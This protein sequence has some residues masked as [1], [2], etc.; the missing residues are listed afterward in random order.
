MP[1]AMPP[2]MPPPDT[3]IP[4][5]SFNKLSFSHDTVTK[6]SLSSAI[7]GELFFYR[8]VPPPLIH[9]FPP[10]LSFN[11]SHSPT[12][13]TIQ[14][15]H[16]VTLST[17]LTAGQL[18]PLH[19]AHVLKSL[20]TLH[21]FDSH[22]QTTHVYANHGR[23][24]EARF[25]AYEQSVY[26][27]LGLNKLNHFDSLLRHL[28]R[29]EIDRRGHPVAVIHGDPVLTNI[30]LQSSTSNPNPNPLKFIDM[31]GALGDRLTIAGDAMYDLAKVFQS[32]LGYDFILADIPLSMDIVNRLS[33][34][35]L[36]FWTQV[37]QL[38]AR[39]D[40]RDVLTVCCGLITSLIPLHDN[41]SHRRQ[42]AAIAKVLLVELDQHPGDGDNGVELLRTIHVKVAH[43]IESKRWLGESRKVPHPFRLK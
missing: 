18:T 4:P 25:L 28:R 26:S 12:V 21:V 5:R 38:Y 40:V 17:L 36:Q 42:F 39:V 9:L 29:Y 20:H 34:Y 16:G 10:L 1:P 37:H 7:D 3:I 2:A 27:Q 15:I 43:V 33:L 30:V 24:V 11:Q 13:F 32:L 14:R 6:S 23:K 35:L 19:I 22:P 31:R 8:N 41:L